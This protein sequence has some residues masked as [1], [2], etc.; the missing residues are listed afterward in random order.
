MST[1]KRTTKDDVVFET[2]G[3]FLDT[4][5]RIDREWLTEKIDE[6]VEDARNHG[7]PKTPEF[8]V[9]F[10][11]EHMDANTLGDNVDTFIQDQIVQYI[12]DAAYDAEITMRGA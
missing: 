4:R 12:A 6:Y 5:I 8:E 9:E 10:L 2:E 7:Y 11:L 3:V 1:T